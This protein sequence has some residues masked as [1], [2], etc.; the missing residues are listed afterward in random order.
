M[1]KGLAFHRSD[2]SGVSGRQLSMPA[3][4]RSP[5]N[6]LWRFSTNSPAGASEYGLANLYKQRVDMEDCSIF[7]D[8]AAQ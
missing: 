3:G 1:L 4:S 7:W 5:T 8:R 6:A 2:A